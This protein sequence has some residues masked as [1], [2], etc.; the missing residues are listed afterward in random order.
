MD[1]KKNVTLNKL[2]LFFVS[3]VLFLPF[4][5]LADQDEQQE[6]KQ[7][8]E[9][10]IKVAQCGSCHAKNPKDINSPLLGGFLVKDSYGQV[11]S[12]N[13]TSYALKTWSVDEIV[14]AL[15]SSLGREGTKLSIDV[16]KAYRWMSNYDAVAIAKVLQSIEAVATDEV[17]RRKISG[18][19]WGILDQ[20]SEVM[21]YVPQLPESNSGYYGLYLVNSV[22]S[23][24]RCH[25][26]DNEL[27]DDSDFL[28]GNK[29]TDKYSLN[30][31]TISIPNIRAMEG[32][33]STWKLANV[34]KFLSTGMRPDNSVVS[35][36]CPTSYFSNLTDR[37]KEAVS[38][39]L[40][41][42]N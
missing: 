32:G 25:S 18:K 11:V 5:S 30:G 31:Q 6:I 17:E 15:R 22:L 9:Y 1:T 2:T 14:S 16:H 19:T 3:I 39:Y 12:P 8:G 10:L 21:G 28:S 38:A 37:D 33:I 42:L 7:R 41:S 23:C 20:H 34:T 29:K 36:E 26:P 13:I 27:F 24:G 4:L 40:I 35:K